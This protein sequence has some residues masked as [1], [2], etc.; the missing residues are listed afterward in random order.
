ML[1]DVDARVHVRVDLRHWCAARRFK[2]KLDLAFE[3]FGI[4]SETEGF[5]HAS[6][7]LFG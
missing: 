4:G 1:G 2:R 3:E 5:Q 6:L 7:H